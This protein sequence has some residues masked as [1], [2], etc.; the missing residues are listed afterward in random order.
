MKLL[1]F[2]DLHLSSIAFSKLRSKIKKHN[3]DL[4]VC[5]GDISIFEEGL[6]QMLDKLNKLKKKVILINGN[7]EEDN[8]MKKLC[9]KHKN[10]FFIHKKSHIEENILFLGYGGGG[11]SMIDK[12]FYNTGEKFSKIIKKNKDKKTILI[13]HAPPYGTKLDLIIGEHCGNKTFLK[14]IKKN[15]INLHL[16][17]HLHENF[18]KKDKIGKTKTINPGP[19]GEIII[20]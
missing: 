17:G 18:G 8:V 14:F 13:T 15:K 6:D 12:E 16:C 9:K 4:L 11:F 1:A 10:L 20:I 5:A 19:Y 2:T 7:H 3:P